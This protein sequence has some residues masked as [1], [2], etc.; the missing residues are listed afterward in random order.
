[1]GDK[2]YIG[3]QVPLPIAESIH[4]QLG[5][6]PMIKK[7]ANTYHLT[8]HFIGKLGDA[9]AI[10]TT[11]DLIRSA[12]QGH[13]PIDI[14]LRGVGCFPTMAR[15]T[16]LYAAVEESPELLR[17]QFD[18]RWYEDGENRRTHHVHKWTPHVTLAQSSSVVKAVGAPYVD[19]DWGA[20]TAY[21][22]RLIRTH[23]VDGQ[24]VHSTAALLPLGKGNA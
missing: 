1:M 9:S 17:L 11:V 6:L 14:Q 23:R 24:T 22:V 19:C 3:I 21:D 16:T 20:F 8:L 13:D 15:A 18:C 2:Y 7:A 10:A 12:I 5:V 4:S